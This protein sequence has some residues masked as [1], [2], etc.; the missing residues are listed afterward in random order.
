M[1]KNVPIW[2]VNILKSIASQI[3]LDTQGK[4]LEKSKYNHPPSSKDSP[5]AVYKTM[6]VNKAQISIRYK[7]YNKKYIF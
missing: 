3:Q 6:E 5:S 7:K 2:E 1:N 4:N